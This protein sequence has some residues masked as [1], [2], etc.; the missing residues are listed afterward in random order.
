MKGKEN[1][2]C[3][4]QPPPISKRHC[5]LFIILGKSRCSSQIL[6]VSWPLLLV[7]STSNFHSSW[8]ALWRTLK[9]RSS[10]LRSHH[11]NH[12]P[13]G[14]S[15]N[16]LVG[17]LSNLRCLKPQKH[18]SHWFPQQQARCQNPSNLFITPTLFKLPSTPAVYAVSLL[19]TWHEIS[20]ATRLVDYSH[21]VS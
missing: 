13:S 17:A 16:K 4:K 9:L 18:N 3:G 14:S 21:Q 12:R 1:R 2:N 11:S 5:C 10:S 19:S 20:T 6:V 7:A 8:F 15:N